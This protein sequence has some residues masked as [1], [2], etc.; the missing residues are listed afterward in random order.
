MPDT[1]LEAT[2]EVTPTWRFADIPDDQVA[3]DVTQRDQFRNDSVELFQSLVREATQNSTDSRAGTD[4]V[5]LRFAIRTLGPEDSAALR[6]LLQPIAMNCGACKLDVGVLSSNAARVLVVEDFNTFGLI[7]SVDQHDDGNFSGFWRRHGGSNKDATKGGSHGLGKL[8]FSTASQ[9]GAIFGLT[10]RQD[11]LRPLLMGQAILNNHKIDGKR[12]PAHG[13]WTPTQMPGQ[14]QLPALDED[15]ISQMSALMGFRRTTETGLSIAVPYVLDDISHEALI[16]AVVTNYFFPILSGD[17]IVEVGD[18]EIRKENFAEI[19]S[20][21]T[22]LSVDEKHRL[23]F[24]QRLVPKLGETPELVLSEHPGNMRLGEVEIAEDTLTVLREQYQ[25]GKIVSV[26][27]PVITQPKIGEN[28]AS[29]VDLFLTKKPEEAGPWALF[30]RESLVLP[31]ESRASFSEAAFGA[32]I[33][34]D[35]AV[36]SLL[37]DAENPAHTKWSAH[38]KVKLN[39]RNGAGTIRNIRLSLSALYRLIT[40]E[41]REDHRDLLLNILSVADPNPKRSKGP[42]TR[43]K[44]DMPLPTPKPKFFSEQR[45]DGGFRLRPGPG[46]EGKEY[47]VRMR[48]R[49]AYDVLSGNPFKLHTPFDFDMSK[50]SLKFRAKSIEVAERL[51]GAI[52]LDCTGPDFALEVTGF[53]VNRDLIIDPRIVT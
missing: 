3:P 26:R 25:S 15:L 9:I 46:A 6:G 40:A 32:L 20:A 5:R 51:P 1:E 42:R 19:A 10:I 22:G 38:E 16:R 14:I 41:L 48:V 24:V 43:T 39:W 37:R 12:L 53:D 50:S 4:P 18:I 17:L 31:G 21:Q 11:D 28:I 47:P 34:R 8:V 13:Y 44:P 23:E 35:P 29:F 52:V 36:C 27:L 7:G 33:A 2:G 30:A 49:V 45:V